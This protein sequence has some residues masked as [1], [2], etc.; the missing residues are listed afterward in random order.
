MIMCV[1]YIVP[2]LGSF[3]LLRYV[4]AYFQKLCHLEDKYVI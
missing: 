2:H 1:R 3:Q 4:K